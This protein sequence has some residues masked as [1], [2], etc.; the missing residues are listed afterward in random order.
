VPTGILLYTMLYFV[1]ETG[2]KHSVFGVGL[3]I[4]DI[5]V[6]EFSSTLEFW[7]HG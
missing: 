5:N 3:V 2:T 4:F 1:S 6:A 7:S